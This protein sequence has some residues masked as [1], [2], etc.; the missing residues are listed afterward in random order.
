MKI[1]YKKDVL[2]VDKKEGLSVD[3]YLFNEYEV[4]YNE[5]KPN[6]IQKWH[7]HEKIW[8]T[9]FIIEGEMTLHW[10]EGSEVK[11]LQVGP[12]TLI[13]TEHTSHTFS[14]NSARVAKFLVFKQI[15]K[16]QNYQDLL[17]KDKILD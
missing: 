1:L 13:E 12:G 4:H 9:L 8:E 3:Y 17:K 14:N 2:H 6:S 16:D 10:R 5:Q 11:A 7:H 15:L